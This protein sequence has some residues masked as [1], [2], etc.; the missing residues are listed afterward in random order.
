MDTQLSDLP[1]GP[2]SVPPPSGFPNAPLS[3]LSSC[4]S[5]PFTLSGFPYSPSGSA[6]SACCLFPFALPCFAPTAVPQVTA[7]PPLRLL[8]FL[9]TRAHAA[10][11]LS[12]TSGLEP[13]LLSLCFFLSLHPG[14]PS[15]SVLRCQS[16]RWPLRLFPCASYQPRYSAFLQFL[17]PILVSHHRCYFKSRP[18]SFD[19]RPFPL[20]FALGSGYLAG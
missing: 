6:Y 13:R 15:Q 8:R 1:F 16:F 4:G 20:A 19:F 18:L 5:S 3:P 9:S 14:F 11:F 7:S 2:P 10:R 17:S 12:S